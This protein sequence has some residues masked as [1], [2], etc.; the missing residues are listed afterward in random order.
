MG[1][2]AIRIRTIHPAKKTRARMPILCW[3][4]SFFVNY[5][6]SKEDQGTDADSLLD[7]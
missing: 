2:D 4:D 6:S 3:M 5:P 7:G 1:S